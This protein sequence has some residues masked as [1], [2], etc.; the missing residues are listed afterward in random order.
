[1]VASAAPVGQPLA[2]MAAL[3]DKAVTPALT[4][5]VAVTPADVDE[6]ATDVCTPLSD[7]RSNDAS[8]PVNEQGLASTIGAPSIGTPPSIG[9]VVPAS[10]VRGVV[11]ASGGFAPAAS[12]DVT[13][14]EAGSAASPRSAL[15]PTAHPAVT[16]IMSDAAK[17]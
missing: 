13:S 16:I 6:A 1:L 11:V 5:A 12:E 15:L 4:S 8:V 9:R 7:V 14:T 17:R 2:F 3:L 10:L